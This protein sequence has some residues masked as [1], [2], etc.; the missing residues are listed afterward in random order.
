MIVCFR[1][2][3]R[4]NGRS[5]TG[6]KATV[7]SKYPLLFCGS[8]RTGVA[9]LY[10][11]GGQKT[12][13]YRIS[14]DGCLAKQHGIDVQRCHDYRE[15]L[16]LARCGFVIAR[17]MIYWRFPRSNQGARFLW[18]LARYKSRLAEGS[19]RR[20]VHSTW[21]QSATIISCL[22]PRPSNNKKK[23]EKLHIA[24]KRKTTKRAWPL[25]LDNARPKVRTTTSD[26]H[27]AYSSQLTT[28]Q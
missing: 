1:L 18:C 9:S 11:S 17:P 23:L 28:W 6:T 25:R 3:G 15:M 5:C 12:G 2:V 20:A 10:V 27:E 21:N 19:G 4:R 26:V 16:G 14:S 22:P 24:R 7:S 13:W 8:E